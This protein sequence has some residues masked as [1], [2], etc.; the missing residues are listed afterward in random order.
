MKLMVRIDDTEGNTYEF[1]LDAWENPV[2]RPV[3]Q[4]VIPGRSAEDPYAEAPPAGWV[5]PRLPR[6]SRVV[7]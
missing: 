4:A 3:E 7:E 1:P 2:N 5:G 6:V